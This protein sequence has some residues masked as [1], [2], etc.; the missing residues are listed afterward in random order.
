M[1]D[2]WIDLIVYGKEGYQQICSFANKG[3][4]VFS[5]ENKIVEGDEISDS[6]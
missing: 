1:K 4:C 6:E 5:T 2:K 3:E